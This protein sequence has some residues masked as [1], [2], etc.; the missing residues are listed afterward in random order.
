MLHFCF[1]YVLLCRLYC[2][3]WTNGFGS[4]FLLWSQELLPL[5]C[6]LEVY[7]VIRTLIRM[8]CALY[9]WHKCRC[10]SVSLHN[11]HLQCVFVEIFVAIQYPL[12]KISGDTFVT[13]HE[14]RWWRGATTFFCCLVTTVTCTWIV[15]LK[16]KD[17]PWTRLNPFACSCICKRNRRVW[18]PLVIA[19]ES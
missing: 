13:V 4:W 12:T 10:M 1:I 15:S 11:L 14:M 7:G 5:F 18:R 2:G 19:P 8:P 6:F 3:R 9:E 17:L 16:S